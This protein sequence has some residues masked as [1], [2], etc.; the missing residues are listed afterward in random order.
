MKKP[1]YESKGKVGA[2]IFIV[3]SLVE[4]ISVLIGKPVKIPPE[5]WDIIQAAGLG[6][7]AWGIRDAIPNDGKGK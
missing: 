4:G 2:L 7:S 3:T 5:V 1:W 6:V